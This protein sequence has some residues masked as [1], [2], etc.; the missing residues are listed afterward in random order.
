[1][2]FNA[3]LRKAWSQDDDGTWHM[4]MPD[5]WNQ[6]RSVFGGLTTAAAAG[7]GL[8]V[9]NPERRLRTFQ[10]QLLRPATPGPIQ[11]T[12]T[13]TREGRNVTFLR[14]SL[15]QNDK[16]VINL[17]MVFVKERDSTVHV[18]PEPVWEG[19]DPET[20]PEMPYIEGITPQMTQHIAFRWVTQNYPFM[21]QPQKRLA[22]YFKL[23]VPTG[24]EE[25]IIGLLDAWPTPTLSM[26]RKPTPSSTVTWTAHLRQIPKDLSNGWCAF[27][28]ETVFAQNGFHTIIGRLHAPDGTLIASTEQL[29]GVFD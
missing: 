15:T 4:T 11:G 12:A 21:G 18:E 25:G 24:D 10:A 9:I 14:A 22:G 28:Y 5:G 19:P 1:M 13:I 23:R 17:D 3:N 26:V 29:V 2:E 27:E 16:A 6:G 20:L 7:L 8:R